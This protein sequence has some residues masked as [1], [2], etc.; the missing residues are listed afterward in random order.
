[1]EERQ[2]ELIRKTRKALENLMQ[3]D[4]EVEV[5]LPTKIKYRNN[6]CELARSYPNIQTLSF[7]VE[8]L[9]KIYM[10]KKIRQYDWIDEVE[11]DTMF[12]MSFNA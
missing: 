9:H 2:E 7:A 1:M 6:L 8:L 10:A 11:E 3:L 12:A 5:F 4:D